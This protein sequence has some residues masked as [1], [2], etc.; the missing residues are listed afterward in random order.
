MD[1][2]LKNYCTADKIAS[3]PACYEWAKNNPNSTARYYFCQQRHMDPLCGES[4]VESTKSEPQFFALFLL[5]I[6]ISVIVTAI[7]LSGRKG[8][9]KFYS[10]F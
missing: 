7:A 1:I 4:F 3:D 6:M 10:N 9:T 2:V 8:N 5:V